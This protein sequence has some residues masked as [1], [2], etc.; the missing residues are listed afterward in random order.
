M[1]NSKV[2]FI[3][4]YPYNDNASIDTNLPVEIAAAQTP[5]SQAGFD[6]LWAKATN[7]NE[8]YNR[9]ATNAVSLTFGHCLS[10]LTMNCKLDASV[11]GS[12]DG[13]TV[14]IKG[15][16]TKNTFDLKTGDL[17]TPDTPAEIT[18]NK[19]ATPPPD[20]PPRTMPS[21]CRAITPTGLYR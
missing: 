8:G 3:A 7:G 4:Y 11:G 17:G 21:S 6:L 20:T 16:N 14:T 15:M 1:D 10:M 13:A 18:P 5:A 19:L 2:D 12:L 9:E